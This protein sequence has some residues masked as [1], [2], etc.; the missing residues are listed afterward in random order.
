ML[1]L[2]TEAVKKEFF[3]SPW[4]RPEK[5]E[6]VLAP[7]MAFATELLQPIREGLACRANY[8]LGIGDVDGAW[9][10]AVTVTR[11]SVKH[12]ENFT[13]VISISEPFY[14]EK[15]ILRLHP[16]S[17]VDRER[18][19]SD[20]DGLAPL[21]SFEKYVQFDRL[22]K[23][24]LVA[25]FDRDP[26]PNMKYINWCRV[27][28]LINKDYDEFERIAGKIREPDQENFIKSFSPY[29]LPPERSFLSE[30]LGKP[31]TVDER[32]KELAYGIRMEGNGPGTV[33]PTLKNHQDR[34]DELRRTLEKGPE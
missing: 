7:P 31:L 2:V 12:N 24:W 22:I 26:A 20:L 28:H 19:L 34:Y 16:V 4:I 15:N 5:A 8:R 14:L 33:F 27:A 1:D 21:F 6:G 18:R 29:F 11:L 23:L 9:S 13:A 10:D 3:F 30:K 32:S 17:D 25:M